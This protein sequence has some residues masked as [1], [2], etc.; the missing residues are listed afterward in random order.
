MSATCELRTLMS[1]TSNCFV[2]PKLH[3]L[4]LAIRDRA[5]LLAHHA[6]SHELRSR[7]YYFC[8][9]AHETARSL[10]DVI[11]ETKLR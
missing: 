9:L 2:T 1:R 5:S 3:V 6:H 10:D 4:S 8:V 11:M 7:A